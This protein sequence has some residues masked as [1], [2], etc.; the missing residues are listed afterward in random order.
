[1]GVKARE[2]PYPTLIYIFI[3]L[4]L[5]LFF[6]LNKY[7]VSQNNLFLLL[8]IQSAF[9]IHYIN[10]TNRD[11]S[12]FFSSVTNE[13]ST[14]VFKN[15]ERTKYLSKSTYYFSFFTNLFQPNLP[16]KTVKINIPKE[17]NKVQ[18]FD[19]SEGE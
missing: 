14:I 2:P 1:M 7:I 12:H 13:D 9:L 3:S 11:L 16:R 8:L 15:E 5:Y 18:F 17:A 10:K 4:H 19:N 6:F